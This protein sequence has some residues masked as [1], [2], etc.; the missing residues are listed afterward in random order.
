MK[1]IYL[2]LFSLII[3]FTGIVKANITVEGEKVTSLSNDAGKPDVIANNLKSAS[4]ASGI[5]IS[6][7]FGD[8]SLP[9]IP[10]FTTSTG[11]QTGRLYR[12]GTP[13]TCGSTHGGF[14]IFELG[15][16]T[17]EAYTFFAKETECTTIEVTNATIDPG[18]EIYVAVYSDLF[19]PINIAEN[20]F[21]E[22]G[23][24][25]AGQT[26]SF[27]TI[28]GQKYV[29][30]V[31]EVYGAGEG[32]PYT[33][34]IT[35][36]SAGNQ[37]VVCNPIDVNLD[38]D[39]NYKL[40][41]LDMI[42][43]TGVTPD[44]LITFDDMKIFAYPDTFTT[45]NIEWPVFVRVTQYDGRFEK[46]RCWA[47]V[48][49]HDSM[50][51]TVVGRDMEIFL[52]SAG[53]AV[54]TKEMLTDSA[55]FDVSGIVSTSI[56]KDTFTCANLGE[57][58]VMLS[59]TDIYGN[60]GTDSVLVTVKVDMPAID[61]IA[62]VNVA[63]LAGDCEAAIEYPIPEFNEICGVS[64]VLT[65][66]LGRAGLFPV[67]TTTETWM[68]IDYKNDTTIVSFNVNVTSANAFPSFETIADVTADGN[69]TDIVIPLTGITYGND[70]AAQSV[71]VSAETDN[72]ELIDTVT[73]AYTDGNTTGDLQV[74]LMPDKTGTAKIT[75]TVTDSEGASMFRNFNLVVN[76]KKQAHLT[77]AVWTK[78]IEMGVSLFPNPA[79]DMVTVDV[80]NYNAAQT[81]VAVFT[82]AGAEVL[83][84]N[85]VS[86]ETIRF[87]MKEQIS[88]V[89]LVKMN[90]DG[91]SI[92]KKLIV[93]KK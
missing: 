32:I 26:M 17:Y 31:S 67:G 74:K 23:R 65:S 88:G 89:Y 49:V 90:I 82:M 8:G 84:K 55:T 34:N 11:L 64:A 18:Y 72:A 6:N 46:K 66:G 71:T 1:K 28:A 4:T 43:L 58:W 76:A 70:C 21:S 24:S 14:S 10:G 44:S 3:C 79:Q 57:N 51:P 63:L 56:D 68:I 45:A 5:E 13:R 2:L 35:N 73:V 9:V 39:G 19:N 75:V 83:R 16:R 52:D 30:V 40:D 38:V 77:T 20:G 60:V 7:V 37:E 80:R 33:I 69:T 91:N 81:E 92:I 53:M 22:M 62:D 50:P 36:V 25:G 48:T 78:E 86:G 42:E 85:Y 12:D 54:I 15:G 93:D 47:M 59:A 27:N 61:S 87:S 41:S 29:M